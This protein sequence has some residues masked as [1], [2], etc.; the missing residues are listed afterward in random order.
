MSAWPGPCL[1]PAQAVMEQ[2]QR[3]SLQ[4]LGH[5][6]GRRMKR[7]L[8]WT[9]ACVDELRQDPVS[10][11]GEYLSSLDHALKNRADRTSDQ[12]GQPEQ[13]RSRSGTASK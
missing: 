13:R 10:G 9:V 6:E 7:L 3:K 8:S 2:D 11:H 4:T 1:V 12:A 5:E